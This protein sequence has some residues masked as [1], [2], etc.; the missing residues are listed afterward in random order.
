[1]MDVVVAYIPTTRVWVGCF[2]ILEKFA[3]AF[4]VKPVAI[5][6]AFRVAKVKEVKWLHVID[7]HC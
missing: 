6:N 7:I 3:H 1:M 2:K 5:L 4:C